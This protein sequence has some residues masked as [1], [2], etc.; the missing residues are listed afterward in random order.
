MK[1]KPSTAA[2]PLRLLPAKPGDLEAR[3]LRLWPDGEPCAE[4]NRLEWIRAVCMVRATTGGWVADRR[5]QRVA[6]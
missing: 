3:A 6:S 5:A 2:G 4:H 1:T